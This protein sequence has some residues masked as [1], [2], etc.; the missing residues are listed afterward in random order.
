MKNRVRTGRRKAEY[1][2]AVVAGVASAF[3]RLR[4]NELVWSNDYLFDRQV[5]LQ[6]WDGPGGF[7]AGTFMKPVYRRRGASIP[8]SASHRLSRERQT[9]R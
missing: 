3:R 9:R 2:V 1:K 8:G 7:Q 6:L 5:G 4:E